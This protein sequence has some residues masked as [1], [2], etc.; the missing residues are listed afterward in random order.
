M[1]HG[2]RGQRFACSL[3]FRGFSETNNAQTPRFIFQ[4]C[5]KRTRFEQRVLGEPLAIGMGAGPLEAL[6]HQRLE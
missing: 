6:A 5:S 4:M 3:A 2:E 1:L